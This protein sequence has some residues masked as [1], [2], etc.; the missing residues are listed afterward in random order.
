MRLPSRFIPPR[1]IPRLGWMRS[2]VLVA[3][4]IGFVYFIYSSSQLGRYLTAAI[5]CSFL[6]YAWIVNKRTN[7]QFELLARSR[8]GDSICEFAG[9]FDTRATDTWIIRAAH[10]ELQA[11]LQ[12]YVRDFPLRASDSLLVD[13]ELDLDDVEE[14]LQD[15]AKRSSRSLAKTEENPYYERLNTVK[16]LVLFVNAQ[17]KTSL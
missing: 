14:L 3:L 9:S 16:D 12:S 15:I 13:L 17:P 5:V 7:R 10:Q 4:L 6:G 11:V 1:V 8:N 2:L